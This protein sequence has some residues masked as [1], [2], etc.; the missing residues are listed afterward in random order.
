MK[1]TT[2]LRCFGADRDRLAA[3]LGI[4]VFSRDDQRRHVEA[5]DAGGVAAGDLGLLVGRHPGQDLRQDLP[6]LGH[7]YIRLPAIRTIISSRCHRS[8]GRGRRRRNR[9]A[10]TGPN[11]STQLRTVS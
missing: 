4:I 3:Q 6:L 10:I 7:R 9:R 11:F 8:L 2:P 1:S 5:V